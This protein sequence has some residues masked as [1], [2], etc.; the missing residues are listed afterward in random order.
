[1]IVKDKEGSIKIDGKVRRDPTFPA[2]IMGVTF[3]WSQYY[4]PTIFLNRILD[5]ISIEKSG[6]NFRVLYDTQGKFVL[7]SL[8]PEEAKV[9]PVSKT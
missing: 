5:V 2:G 6:E 8:K 4:N 3:I 9:L 7:K 1:M